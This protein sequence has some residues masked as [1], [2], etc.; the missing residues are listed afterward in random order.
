M[1]RRWLSMCFVPVAALL[2]ACTAEPE[3]AVPNAPPA[4]AETEAPIR[5]VEVFGETVAIDSRELTVEL[6]QET[7]DALHEALNTLQSAEHVTLTRS[8]PETDVCAWEAAWEALEQAFPNVTFDMRTQYRGEDADKVL[9]LTRAEAPTDEE[10][11]AVRRVFP[12]LETLD[13]TGADVSSEAIASIVSREPDL[14]LLWNDESFGASDSRAETLTLQGT[15][16]DAI[17]AYLACFPNLKEVDLRAATISEEAGDALTAAFPTVAL[18]RNVTLNGT[19][20][21]SFVETLDLQAA[22]ISDF[23]AFSDALG[24]FP[25]IKRIELDE[26]DL[27]NEQ[28]GALQ[29]RYPAVKVVWTVRFRGWSVRTDAVAF[30]TMQSSDNDRRLSEQEVSVLQYCTDLI[31]LDLGHNDIRSIEWIAPLRNLQVLILADNRHLSDIRPLGELKKLKYVELFLE[32]S[33]RDISPLAN[34]S[35]LLDVNLCITHVEDLTPLLSCKKLER[36]WIGNQ[37]QEFITKESLQAV[38]EAF[39]NA[40][41]DLT[42][43]SCTNRGWREH[44][45]FFAFRSMFETQ[46]P[47]EPFLPD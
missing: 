13:L 47:V 36:I 24:R 28:L 20:Y 26:C 25:K 5:T 34:L 10:L 37:S 8:V 29:A 3:T 12:A 9:L 16:A 31:V 17:G 38:L 11:A 43:V 27:R 39:P 44:P 30:S 4:V 2:L 15:D 35:E 21:D 18:H 41:Y 7:P 46:Q 23:D 32:T 33:L 42:S 19:V 6:L 40:E 45:R 1:N 14:Q 22:K